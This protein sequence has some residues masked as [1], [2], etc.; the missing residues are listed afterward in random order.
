MLQVLAYAKSFRSASLNSQCQV[1]S[2]KPAQ[3]I[4]TTNLKVVTENIW[5]MPKTNY[6]TVQVQKHVKYSVMASK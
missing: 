2:R 5:G 1:H 3:M 4:S 6:R